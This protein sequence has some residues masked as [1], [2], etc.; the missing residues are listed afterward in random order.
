[1]KTCKHI[2]SSKYGKTFF[3]K[4]CNLTLC[5]NCVHEYLSLKQCV[6]C[7]LTFNKDDLNAT[8]CTRCK[9]CP[10]CKLVV[11]MPNEEGGDSAEVKPKVLRRC[12]GCKAK[13]GGYCKYNVTYIKIPIRGLG[14][15]ANSPK[16]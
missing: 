7:G 13:F 2:R 6:T 10:L 12:H 1:M 11:T 15:G 3:C 5:K 4:E 16:G 14:V 8:N 9:R